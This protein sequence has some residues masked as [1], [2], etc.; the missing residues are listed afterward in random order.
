MEHMP[1]PSKENLRILITWWLA[2]YGTL[3]WAQ[4]RSRRAAGLPLAY[5]TALSMIHLA[6]AC[7]Y[8][9]ENYQP[10]SA[11]LTQ[12]Q[13]SLL[14]TF[15][16]FYVSVIGFWS[17]IIGSLLCPLLFNKV[18]PKVL[19][20]PV[21]QV[22]TDLPVTLLLI[23]LL[24]FFVMR[25]I[26]NRIPSFASIASSG[27]YMSVVAV[28][29]IIYQA[30]IARNY[31]KVLKWFG[32][33]FV[34]PTVTIV[35]MGFAGFGTIA[36]AITWTFVIRFF[37]PRWLSVTVFGLLVYIG[38][39]LYVNYMRERDSIRESVWG[40]R[41]LSSR[42]DRVSKMIENFEWFSTANQRHLEMVDMRLN[43]NDIVG[44][45]VIYIESGRVPLAE[46]GTLAAAALAWIP[47]ILWPD[48]PATG[49]SGS[50]VSRFTGM[51]F[52]EGT[53]V[54]VGQVLEFYV[55]WKL[56]SVVGCFLVLGLV[57]TWI[58]QKAGTF[59][60]QGDLWNTA[61]WMVPGLGMLQA[62][63]SSTEMV[64]SV[65][66]GVVFM[67]ALHHYVFKRFYEDALAAPRQ[68]YNT[69]VRLPRGSRVQRQSF[70]SR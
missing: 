23:S 54:G 29:L 70:H 22:T 9:V 10:R 55:N 18:P 63:G 19:K 65:A 16:G 13:Y 14:N 31:A 59:M 56:P 67:W 30:Y 45:A 42:I 39:S 5:A 66:G 28:T 6:G 1:F 53:S 52:A 8:A 44:K 35:T 37:R 27:T 20:R 61:R 26:M 41:E 40:G 68:L 46:G 38:M 51:K 36:A 17:F 15:T 4:W 57:L 2:G 3:L 64:S 48:K 62:G 33:T 47:R 7:V 12:S 11:I 60:Q 50:I 32:A 69:D 21:P 25:P 24:F 43:Q 34:F 49:G 58:D